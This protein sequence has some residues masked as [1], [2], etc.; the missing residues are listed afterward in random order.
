MFLIVGLTVLAVTMALV[1]FVA[2]RS[3]KKNDIS[4]LLEKVDTRTPISRHSFDAYHQTTIP[5]RLSSL[6]TLSSNPNTHLARQSYVPSQA[7]LYAYPV[8]QYDSR[9]SYLYS[10]PAMDTR[11]YSDPRHTLLY[12]NSNEP[13]SV[14]RVS[15]MYAPSITSMAPIPPLPLVP[16]ANLEATLERH[17]NSMQSFSQN[18][19]EATNEPGDMQ[20]E[21]NKS[22]SHKKSRDSMHW[23]NVFAPAEPQTVDRPLSG[24]EF[25]PPPKDPPSVFD[26]PQRQLDIPRSQ[27]PE[28]VG[29]RKFS[30]DYGPE[31]LQRQANPLSPIKE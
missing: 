25:P 8:Q 14:H 28:I 7:E 23:Q 20:K 11:L 15:S 6:S 17:Q 26:Y 22:A 30:F 5:R 24:F 9:Y 12:L 29:G 1:V 18:L 4:A 21:D 19:N 16:T 10:D 2:I 27:S 3:F 31:V 13:I